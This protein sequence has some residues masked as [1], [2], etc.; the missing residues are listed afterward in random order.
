MLAKKI[1]VELITQS[2]PRGTYLH[3]G[4]EATLSGYGF[5]EPQNFLKLNLITISQNLVLLIRQTNLFAV[6]NLLSLLI[7]IIF[8]FVSYTTIIT[9]LTGQCSLGKRSFRSLTNVRWVS[10]LSDP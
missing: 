4:R 7:F 2:R 1:L 6:I 9:G 5:H 3:H 10:D 8:L